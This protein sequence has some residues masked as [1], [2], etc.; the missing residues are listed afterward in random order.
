MAGLRL[1]ERGDWTLDR[2]GWTEVS[3]RGDCECAVHRLLQCWIVVDGLDEWT[4]VAE[5]CAQR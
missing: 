4:G 3:G 1:L 2:G 5:H